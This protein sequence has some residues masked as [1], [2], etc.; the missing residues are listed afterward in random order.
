MSDVR[1]LLVDDSLVFL[2]AAANLLAGVSGIVVIGQATS[3]EEAVAQVNSLK[4]ELVL[5]D[6]EMPGMNGLQAMKIIKKLADPPQVV[7]V[8][9]HDLEEYHA[10]AISQ[11]ADG[12][13]SKSQLCEL[14]PAMLEQALAPSN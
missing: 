7:I 1:V 2:D 13:W 9:L 12:F 14:V 5:M 11:G 6:W 10:A 3:G 8:S 4:P